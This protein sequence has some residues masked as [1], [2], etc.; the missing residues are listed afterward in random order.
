[1]ERSEEVRL[2]SLSTWFARLIARPD[3][4][5]L[6]GRLPFGRGM[7]RRDGAEIFEILQGFVAS[8]VLVALVEL[9]ILKR[10]LDGP[11]TA[12]NLALNRGIPTDRMERLLR[13]AVALKLL[14]RKRNGSFALA[15]RGAAILGVP[16]LPAMIQHN[17]AF[18]RDMAD[19]VALLRGEDETNLQRFW[20][21]VFGQAPEIEPDVAARY[22]DLMAQSQVL[23]AQDTLRMLSL[24]GVTRLLDVGGGTGVFLSH[25]LRQHPDLQAMLFDLPQVLPAAEG[26]IARSGLSDR[27][28]FCPGSF[29]TG[30]LPEGADAVSLIRVLYD[31]DDASV[32]AL[33][34]KIFAYLPAG[35]RL[36]ISEPMAGSSAPDRAGD[37]YFA[38][39]TMAMGTGKARSA[40]EIASICKAAGFADMRIPRAPR[41]YITSALTCVK[42]AKKDA[43]Y[44]VKKT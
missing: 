14:R 20:P 29:R 6:A 17:Q 18:Y 1:M 43:S 10:L 41:P 30:D 13:A 39:Y 40:R 32:V 12:A 2:R 11:Q 19:P 24:K 42:P 27:L 3:I 38:L 33:I 5:D 35:G 22:S 28:T 31:H 44:S 4:Q 34:E 26:F 8:Q 16:G 25:A 21:Y 23:V 36:I 37:V 7:A 9:D 15:R